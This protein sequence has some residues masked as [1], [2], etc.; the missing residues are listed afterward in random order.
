MVLEYQRLCGLKGQAQREEPQGR[1]ATART[2]VLLHQVRREAARADVRWI[3]QRLQTLSGR[4]QL[5]HALEH[6]A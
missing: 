3:E 4:R 6:A 1:W 5:R 2:A